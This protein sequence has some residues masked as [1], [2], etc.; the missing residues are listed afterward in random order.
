MLRTPHATRWADDE[1][2]VLLAA[3]DVYAY[4]YKDLF[5][6]PVGLAFDLLLME[7]SVAGTI[8]RLE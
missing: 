5:A 7:P 1:R 2:V 6:P 4:V 3:D 8:I